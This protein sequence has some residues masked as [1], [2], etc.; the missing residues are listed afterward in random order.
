MP[1]RL[2]PSARRARKRNE[3]TEVASTAKARFCRVGPRKAR[4]IADMIRGMRV[5]E[6][7]TALKLT[8]RPSVI[9]IIERLLKSAVANVDSSAHP[10]T[11]DLVIG[12]IMVD[13]AGMLKRWQ[14]RAMG[15]ACRIRK[16]L[17]HISLKLVKRS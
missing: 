6:A 15:R 14:P 11:D 5:D 16:R 9:A 4:F 1:S 12:T 2:A 10:E 8:H 7:M 17:C 3:K 13:G